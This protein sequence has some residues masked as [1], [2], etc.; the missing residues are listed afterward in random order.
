M[1]TTS[2]PQQTQIETIRRLK[3][4]KSVLKKAVLSSQQSRQELQ[5]SMH[6]LS[7]SKRRLE[8]EI[9]SHQEEIDRLGFSNEQLKRRIT[10]M[11]RDFKEQEE[12][13]SASVS[14]N[15]TMLGRLLGS[16]ASEETEK[17]QEKF[18][19]LQEELNI[20]I[21]ENECVLMKQFEL[22][23][24]HEEQV[25]VLRKE[26][27]KSKQKYQEINRE[28]IS[29]QRIS[30]KLISEKQDTTKKSREATGTFEAARAS[31]NQRYRDMANVNAELNKELDTT[32]KRLRDKVP[33]DDGSRKWWNAW[34]L[35]PHD[36]TKEKALVCGCIRGILA[37]QD[38][39]ETYASC[40]DVASSLL[41]IRLHHVSDSKV[42]IENEK[43]KNIRETEA[44]VREKMFTKMATATRSFIASSLSS[45]RSPSF[46]TPSSSPSSSSPSSPSSSPSSSLTEK[47]VV[48][49]VN[50]NNIRLILEM[51]EQLTRR[52]TT[53]KTS[54]ETIVSH[55]VHKS[56]QALFS[57]LL[58]RWNN[59]SFTTT[60][61]ALVKDI[62]GQEENVKSCLRTKEW[63]I[64][65]TWVVQIA[66]EAPSFV[67]QISTMVD[68][69]SS[70]L[71]E[72]ATVVAQRIAEEQRRPFVSKSVRTALRRAQDNEFK[73][74]TS[75][76]RFAEAIR[77]VEQTSQK[78][79]N[80]SRNGRSDRSDRNG[81]NNGNSNNNSN[82]NNN[83][84]TTSFNEIHNR[85]AIVQEFQLKENM[86]EEKKSLEMASLLQQ[87]RGTLS[88]KAKSYHEWI[89]SKKLIAA[90]PHLSAVKFRD[91]LELS[92]KE[93]NELRVRT[94]NVEIEN[95]TLKETAN[96]LNLK[97]NETVQNLQSETNNTTV[98]ESFCFFSS[99]V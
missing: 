35:P 40:C 74:A 47:E 41:R 93:T 24:E 15:S 28:L 76:E 27:L 45:S 17:L 79:N 42:V 64:I 43:E 3:K 94:K 26:V 69:V 39:M 8:A 73:V 32:R 38:L 90:L 50:N 9:Q 52:I 29:E 89:R 53:D 6:S 72:H 18:V 78:G 19:V 10:Q 84:A 81:I 65:L 46:P 98:C 70:A 56:I 30:E 34:T 75:G 5:G 62:L 33:F 91:D 66:R 1:S 86:E 37:L 7:K 25:I 12:E 54:K 13:R 83:N 23:K 87:M 16:G 58:I 99:S 85:D 59:S 55:A 61:S 31:M 36:H 67:K 48:N 22:Q 77:Y 2:Q 88:T 80:R 57:L 14:S 63:K 60:S 96:Q 92:R 68:N 95:E 44:R 21:S 4:E 71:R 51:H 97:Y 49:V 82:D 11:I 20:K